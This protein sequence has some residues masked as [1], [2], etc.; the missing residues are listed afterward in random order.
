MLYF[1]TNGADIQKVKVKNK[2]EREESYIY[3][4]FKLWKNEVSQ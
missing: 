4:F 1:F 3:I 2:K